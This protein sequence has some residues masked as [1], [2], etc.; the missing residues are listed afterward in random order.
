MSL[1]QDRETVAALP[2]AVE[3]VDD[4]ERLYTATE[5]AAELGVTARA[6][7]FYETKGLVAPRRHGNRRIYDYRD[8]ARLR[9]V[10]RGKRLGFSLA[11]IRRYLELYD[12]DPTQAR[13][14]EHLGAAVARRIQ[15][16]EAQR[17]VL[18][19]TLADLRAIQA[20]VEAVVRGRPGNGSGAP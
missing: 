5:L 14:V 18:D 13:Q 19:E 9:L 7:R 8:H 4:R 16:L 17:R 20:Q 11:E 10:L 12:A 15:D 6:L 2:A 3:S 1:D